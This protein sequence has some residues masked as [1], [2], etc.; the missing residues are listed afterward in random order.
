MDKQTLDSILGS[1]GRWLR[2]EQVGQRAD[3][4]GADL[5]GAYLQGAN[6]QEANLRRADLQEANLR[7]ADLQGANLQGANLQGA[8]LQGANLQGA[9]LRRA[10]LQGAD[11]QGA[12]LRRADLQGAN[13][14]W[15]DLDLAICR[16]DF[17]G[18]SICVYADRTSI[19]CQTHRNESWL[20]W[21][22]ESREIQAMHTKA[23]AWWA[24]HGEAV[25]AVIRCVQA[26]GETKPCS[27]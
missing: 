27:E 4:Q 16:L 1:H 5:Q 17:G 19:G 2:G 7:G 11:L 12:D 26:K 8:D 23:S 3:L 24:I 14:R 18:W 21:S 10:D 22:H 9:N 20:S 25:K 15:A 6:L 13:L